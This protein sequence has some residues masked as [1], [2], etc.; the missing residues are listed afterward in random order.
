MQSIRKRLG[1][2]ADHAGYLADL[3]SR[4]KAKRNLMKLL[5]ANHKS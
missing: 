1:A 3:M 4:H 5:Q 2:S